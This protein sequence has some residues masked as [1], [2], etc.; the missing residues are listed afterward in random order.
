MPI[1][2]APPAPWYRGRRTQ[3]IIVRLLIVAAIT[4]GAIWGLRFFQQVRFLYQQRQ[5][6]RYT[7]PADR[8]VLADGTADV[9]R[10]LKMP[11]Y[12]PVATAAAFNPPAAIYWPPQDECVFLH[13]L[14]AAGH[15][16][17]LVTVTL[18]PQPAFV[19]GRGYQLIALA[20]TPAALRPGSRPEFCSVNATS[21]KLALPVA[22]S[23]RVY[24]GQLDPADASHFTI[25]CDL[26]GKQS[27]IDGWLMPDDSV[28]LEAR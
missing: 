6:M 13:G 26:G 1:N 11:D 17:K 18:G 23:L 19:P 22:D 8:I 16:E 20:Q 4:C 3:R 12:R 28:K 25:R 27:T 15:P 9:A 14:H 5:W 24:A 7:A 10:L 2:Y 21:G